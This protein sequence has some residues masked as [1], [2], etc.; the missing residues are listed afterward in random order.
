MNILGT[1]AEKEKYLVTSKKGF[2]ISRYEAGDGS[3]TSLSSRTQ[4]S[5]ITG[6][7]VSK[8]DAYVYN[9]I[10]AE[11]AKEKAKTFEVEDGTKVKSGLITGIQWDMVMK[12]VDDKN[13][14]YVTKSSPTR[15]LDS[16][17]QSGQNEADKVCNIYDLEGNYYEITAELCRK[18]KLL[19]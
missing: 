17:K 16:L 12:F 9:Y 13:K 3:A 1:E 4:N 18:W 11:E 14:F 7:L 2:Y 6:E 10:R 8:K 15:H 19:C 5:G